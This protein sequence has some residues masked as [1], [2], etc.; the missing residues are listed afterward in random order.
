MKMA[1]NNDNDSDDDNDDDD[2][3]VDDG[4]DNDNNNHSGIEVFDDSDKFWFILNVLH[5]ERSRI[6]TQSGLV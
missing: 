1:S 2:D 5:T 6:R 4:D 3:D